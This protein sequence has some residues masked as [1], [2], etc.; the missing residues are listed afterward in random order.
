[1]V[2]LKLVTNFQDTGGFRLRQQCPHPP[3]TAEGRDSQSL[4]PVNK[5]DN[6]QLFILDVRP[7]YLISHIISERSDHIDTWTVETYP[8]LQA[9]YVRARCPSDRQPA[10]LAGIPPVLAARGP[11]IRP[12]Q[13]L[14]V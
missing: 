7:S 13:H 5:S 9:V 3:W 10:G 11:R 8:Y 6:Y 2:A 12:A 14:V 1:M 4:R